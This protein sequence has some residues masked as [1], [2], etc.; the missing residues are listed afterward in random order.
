MGWL[1]IS[2]I[3]SCLYVCCKVVEGEGVCLK[4][5]NTNKFTYILGYVVYNIDIAQT[6]L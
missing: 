4:V 6:V 1:C 3:V 5:C 2:E